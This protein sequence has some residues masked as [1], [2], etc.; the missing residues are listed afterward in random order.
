RAEAAQADELQ[1][2]GELLKANAHSIPRGAAKAVL[3]DYSTGEAREVEVEL[4]P[5]EPVLDQAREL[6]KRAKKLER[7]LVS[8]ETRL[9]EADGRIEALTRLEARVASADTSDAL[10]QIERELGKLG[11]ALPQDARPAPPPAAKKKVEPSGPRR[12]VSRDKLQVLV[13]RSNEE[14]D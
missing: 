7:G 8:V 6:F 9:G 1:K 14:N 2:R 3:T 4:D 5:S 13:G 12:F 10:D 11:V